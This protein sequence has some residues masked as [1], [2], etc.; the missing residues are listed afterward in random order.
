MNVRIKEKCKKLF[1]IIKN[2]WIT[3]WLII[4]ILL[5]CITSTYAAYTGVTQSKRVISLSDR[6]DMLFSSRYMFVN[7]SDVQKI[8]FA[9]NTEDP[10]IT[11]DVCNYDKSGLGKYG[12]DIYFKISARLINYDGT[13]TNNITSDKFN[14]AFIDGENESSLHKLSSLSNEYQFITGPETYDSETGLFKLEGGTKNK[15]K[16]VLHFDSSTLSSPVYAVEVMAQPIGKYDDIKKISG[17]VAA[18]S[19]N[20]QSL[21]WSGEFTDQVIN[22]NP[23][24]FDAYNYVISGIGKGTITLTYDSTALELDRNDLAVFSQLS[25]Y[26]NATANGNTVITFPVDTTAE[27]AVSRYAIHFYQKNGEKLSDFSEDF[28]KTEFTAN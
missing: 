19:R 18:V 21:E 13:E 7:G 28:V 22:N 12:S 14:I 27:N 15:L 2:A 24:Y 1:S 26:T 10:T 4:V 6:D 11:I 23:S 16:F 8:G 17:K 5:F 25:G 9:E 3:V 20:N